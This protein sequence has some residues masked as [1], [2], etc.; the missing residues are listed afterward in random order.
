VTALLLDIGNSRVKWACLREPYRRGQRFAARGVLELTAVRARREAF[1]RPFMRAGRGASLYVCN[2]AGAAVE[3]QVIAAAR[4]AGLRAPNFV[5]STRSAGGV[6]TGYR[7]PW[8]LG[9]DRWLGLIGAHHEH[10]RAALCIVSIGTAMTIDLLAA[11]GQHRGGSIAPGPRLM[12]E[13]LLERTAGIRARAGGAAAAGAFDRALGSVRGVRGGRAASTAFRRAAAARRAAGPF[14]HD[15]QA[16]LLAGAR[17]ATA[18]LI[19]R[20]LLE[21]RRQLSRRPRLL[22]AGGGAAAIAPLLR[23][24][25]SREDDLVLRG[26]AVLACAHQGG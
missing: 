25:H 9:T 23:S 17:Y 22:L 26:L 14:A 10:P 18:A 8:R 19:E 12:I 5:R 20:S 11:D 16:A 1:A 24:R 13:S 4:R 21:A 15:T 2:V 7:D 3:R 6:R